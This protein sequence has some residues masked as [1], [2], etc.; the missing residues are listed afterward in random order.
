[1]GT[2]VIELA[3]EALR[4]ENFTVWEASPGG[5][6]PALT[7]PVAAVR[8]EK[9][10]WE[11]P[12]ATLAVILLCPEALGP[13]RCQEEAMRA[14]EVLTC[15]GAR[16]SQGRCSYDGLAKT[17]TVEV[18]A[19]F[20]GHI[21]EKEFVPETGASHPQET[22][23]FKTFT[24]PNNPDHYQ[25][26]LTREPIFLKNGVYWSYY[27]MQPAKRV[28]TGSG[29]FFGPNAHAHFQALATLYAD[30]EPGILT[31]PVWGSRNVHFIAL[32]LK[33]S[34]KPNYVAYSFEF[35]EA[36]ETGKIPR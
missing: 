29:A 9:V 10:D 11:Q 6:A 30:N 23:T 1:M 19:A 21:Q 18:L 3:L 35:R 22:M 34:G 8:I 27:G 24:W 7:G 25:E 14:G 32:E 33:Q 4:A 36:D 15:A 2:P 31:H 26:E 17:F 5:K 12:E 28:I 16:C 13:A 20:S